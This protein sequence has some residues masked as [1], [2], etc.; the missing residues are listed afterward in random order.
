MT[1]HHKFNQL[2]EKL[3]PETKARVDQKTDELTQEIALLELQQ[4][5][6]E[7]QTDMYVNHL[8]ELISAMGG[9]L[10][11]KARFPDREVIINHFS[12]LL[13]TRNI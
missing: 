10:I 13:K 11:I 5:F 8:R 12:D 6:M 3:S 2:I 9:E 1:G 4:G 7:K